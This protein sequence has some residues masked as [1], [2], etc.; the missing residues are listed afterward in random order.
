MAWYA[1]LLT[2]VFTVLGALTVL[3]LR[4]YLEANWSTHT[5]ER[6]FQLQFD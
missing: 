4:R 3:L 6:P 2:V 1:G 5:H